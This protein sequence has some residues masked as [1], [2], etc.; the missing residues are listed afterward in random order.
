MPGRG[1]PA[2]LA[3]ALLLAGCGAREEASPLDCLEL[4]PAPVARALERAPAK[5][6]LAGGSALSDCVRLLARSDA[7]LQ[8]LTI[9]L[10]RVADELRARADEDPAAALRLGYLAGAV[11]RGAARTPGLAAQLARRIDQVTVSDAGGAPPRPEL[12]RGMQRGEAEG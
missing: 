4:D 11:R 7:E 9:R 6:T 3:A 2:A 10:M 5:V 8:G 12:A 1:V